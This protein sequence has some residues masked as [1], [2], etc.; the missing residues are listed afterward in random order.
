MKKA[1]IGMMLGLFAFSALAAGVSANAGI[2][3][4]VNVRAYNKMLA[5]SAGSVSGGPGCATSSSNRFVI[6]T[7]TDQGKGMAATISVAK[8]S[9]F[10]LVLVGTGSCDATFTD[11][12]VLDT[13]YWY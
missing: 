6:D 5:N 9:G 11:S 12:E 10:S 1:L 8:A 7:S 13:I 4:I 2:G 3:T